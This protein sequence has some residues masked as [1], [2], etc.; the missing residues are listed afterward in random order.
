MQSMT[1]HIEQDDLTR[2]EVQALLLEHL[3]D[4]RATSP[5]ESVHALD[6]DGLRED[7]STFWTAW[8]NGTLLGCGALLH[9][10]VSHGEMKS[11]RTTPSARGL[12]VATRMLRHIIAEA[13]RR[14]YVRLSLETGAQD[15]FAPARKLYRKHGFTECA[16]FADY[17]P[18]PN[19]VFLSATI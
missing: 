6:I 15:F 19:S 9:L 12:G 18:D 4:M 7:H 1:V 16:P 3:R 8:S 11:M 5:K 2:P 10:E 14:G 17:Q 13:R